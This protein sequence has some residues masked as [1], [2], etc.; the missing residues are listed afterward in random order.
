MARKK[1]SNKLQATTVSARYDAAGHGRRLSGWT[2]PSSGPNQAIKGLQTI[3]NRSRDVARN[4]WSGAAQTRIWSTNLVGTGIVPRPT[5]K[6]QA[7][8]RK[9][10]D[11][12]NE[13]VKTMDADGVLDFYGLQALGVRTWFTGGEFFIR[14]RTRR[15]SDGLAVPLQVQLL[16]PDMCPLLDAD[17]YVGLPTENIIRQGIEFDRIG[18][19][20]AVWFY[21]NHPGEAAIPNINPQD[22]TRVPIEQVVHV[23]EP[24]RPGQIRGVPE[25]SSVITRLRNTGDFDDN[26]LER[27]RLANLFTLFITR[28]LPSGANDA[29]T[30]LPFAGT[31]AEP[32]AGLEPGISQ[33]LL[34][35]EDVKFSDPPDA[36]AN[37]AEFMRLQHLG[38]T[39]G[40]GT[41]YELT[42]GDIKDISDR[43]LRIVINEFRRLCEQRQWLIFIPMMCQPVRDWWATHAYLA[44]VLTEDEATEARKVRWSPQAWAYIHPVQD[45]QAKQTEV[46]AGFRSRSS[47]VAERGDDPDEVDAERAEDQK[48][49]IAL[50]LAFEPVDPNK[51]QEPSPADKAATEKAEAEAL[52]L[53]AKVKREGDE[54][55]AAL[56]RA[57]AEA[58]RLVAEAALADARAAQAAAEQRVAEA[59]VEALQAKAAS[60]TAFLELRKAIEERESQE[61]INAL[62]AQTEA[63]Q[64]EAD[65]KATALE[66]AE[67]FARE[68]RALVLATERA[69]AETAS[70]EVEAARTGLEELRGG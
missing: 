21:R 29:M 18:R 42:T 62:L 48:R 25:M 66:S 44:G 52:L 69:R 23:F 55:K 46:E 1:R 5:T 47:V 57:R 51:P 68:Q 20:R 50:G 12:W 49:E 45:V 4:E 33:E 27:Q 58:E 14:M 34:P 8:K 10:I 32:I 6:N 63:A 56:I 35:G 7:L 61:R 39:A 28:A 19:R 30:G 40:G 70:I 3:R 59:N 9:L 54:G 13:S 31:N 38:I 36:G 67:T 53:L 16:E 37:Y 22:L 43:T 26:V 60:D 41:P 64:R 17:T 24:Q 2:T 15:I 11:L 65:A